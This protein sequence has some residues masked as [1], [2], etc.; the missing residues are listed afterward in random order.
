MS[1]EYTP[2]MFGVGFCDEKIEFK[3]EGATDV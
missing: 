1:S 3:K 2:N